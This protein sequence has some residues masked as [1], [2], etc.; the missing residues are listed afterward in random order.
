MA[1]SPD[2]QDYL[3]D[4]L[5]AELYALAEAADEPQDYLDDSLDAELHALAEAF[6]PVG[7][8][9]ERFSIPDDVLYALPEP[10]LNS[11]QQLDC[12]VGEDW[13][14]STADHEL[15]QAAEEEWIL[16]APA[17]VETDHVLLE[18]DET[19]TYELPPLPISSPAPVEEEINPALKRP[20]I[21]A[22]GPKEPAT[23]PTN[24]NG[25]LK[26]FVRGPFPQEVQPRGVVEGLSTR[27]LIKTCFRIGEA[28]RV[29]I[30][31]QRAASTESD[32][33][34][35]LYGCAPPP[36]PVWKDAMLTK[37]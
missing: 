23:A 24:P 4:S 8:V 9:V 19:H 33:L 16:A 27:T 3:D 35:E 17:E 22:W 14:P 12:V 2:S 31:A 6:D 11:S 26:A 32:I 25:S 29:G 20:V 28:L 37:R 1:Q 34:V 36:F 15:D 21:S 5:D 13:I 7:E 30:A 10:D 18:K